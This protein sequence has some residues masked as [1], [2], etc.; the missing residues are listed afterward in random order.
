MRGAFAGAAGRSLA[1]V[2]AAAAVAAVVAV[3][4]TPVES[5][6]AGPGGLAVCPASEVARPTDRGPVPL[7]PWVVDHGGRVVRLHAARDE[8]VAFQIV[9]RAPPAAPPR[10]VDVDVSDLVGPGGAT[11]H[12]ADAV[13]RFVAHP[14]WV[15]P[16]RH[17]W[18]VPSEVL[19]WPAAYPDALVPLERG[20]AAPPGAD[21]P[22]LPAIVVPPTGGR[23]RSVWIDLWV[24]RGTPKGRFDGWVTVRAAGEEA[25]VAVVLEVHAATLPLAPSLHA[26]AEVYEPYVA[27]G[28][29]TSRASPRW[30]HMARCVQELAHR[31][32]AVF[33]EREGEAPGPPAPPFGPD[34]WASYDAAHAGAL[35]GSLFDPA[36]GYRGPG[37]HTPAGIWRVPW[38]ERAYRQIPAPLPDAEIARYR[39]LAAAWDEHAAARGWRDSRFVAYL[40]DEV[41]T[42][43]DLE[44]PRAI[45]PVTVRRAHVEIRRVQEALDAGARRQRIDLMWVGQADPGGW[46]GR[47]GLDLTGTIRLW[48][49]A[50]AAAAPPFLRARVRAGEGAWFYHGGHPFVGVHVVNAPGTELR[51][52]GWIAARYGLTGMLMWAVNLGHP[53]RPYALP[54][55]TATDDRFGNGTLFY[56]GGK[57]P[58]IGVPARAEPVPSMRLKAWR[59]GLQD[60]DL[61]ALGR[62]AGRGA[63]VDRV[64]CT[65]VPRAL[66]EGRGRAAWSRDPEAWHRARLRLLDLAQPVPAAGP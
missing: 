7:E 29:G 65:I 12:A 16:G 24:P 30:Q 63:A 38:P 44:G 1:I 60:A 19:P 59:A 45:D 13:R 43:Q 22:T 36:L 49:P 25:R 3:R 47:Q 17:S 23:N 39:A 2:L 21:A 8:T 55:A 61:A 37:Q 32:R 35:D 27:E 54:S 50:A 26:M 62:A 51:A 56:P 11:I 14:V 5:C 66:A 57:L 64:L 40:F 58:T 9:L 34:E 33:V 46:I 52:W 31:H 15:E 4:T 20:C 48:V 18:G 6:F 42:P 10:V 53:A 28:L 41:D